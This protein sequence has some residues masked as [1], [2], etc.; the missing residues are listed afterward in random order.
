MA[1]MREVTPA[2]NAP[3]TPTVDARQLALALDHSANAI[4]LCDRNAVIQY[5][6]DGFFRMF[7][8]TREEA[9]GRQ[10][11]HL[12]LGTHT[13]AETIR[14]LGAHHLAGKPHR[15]DVLGYRRDGSPLWVS[16]VATPVPAAD[17]TVDCFINVLTDITAAKTHEVLQNKVLDALV[18]E[19]SLAET[20]SLIC[21]EIERVAPDLRASVSQ[22][23][24]NH[25][26][27]IIA[28]P[29]LPTAL[30]DYLNGQPVGVG[31]GICGVAA[32][33][34]RP[35]IVADIAT[36][37]LCAA[38]AGEL[39]SSG[40]RACWANPI[41]SSS[42]QVLGTLAFHYLEAREPAPWHRAL[43]ELSLHLC[44]LALER[45]HTRARVHQLA[46][47]DA[48]TGLP[49][50]M[51]FT[52]RAEQLLASCEQ[53]G[54]Q[55]A[56]LFIG[57]DRFK[58]INESQGHSAGD[59]LL[60]DVA[61]RMAGVVGPSALFG[62]QV[63]DEFLL[64]VPGCSAVQTAAICERLL[65]AIAAPLNVGQITVNASA[66]IGVAMY[67]VDG[68]DI[69]TLLR[70]ADL[71]MYR[72]KD[73]GGSGFR[74][75][76]LDMNR[77]AQERVVME[78]ALREALR[79]DQLTLHYQPQ[80]CSRTQQLSGVEALL[81]WEHPHMGSV[82]PARFIP[83]A[84]ECGLMDELSLWVL[85]QACDDLGH[86]RQRGVPVPRISVNLSASNF[87]NATLPDQLRGLLQEYHLGAGD[88]V[89]EM[90][91]SVMLSA[92]A[93]VLRNLDALHALGFCLSLDDFGTGYSSLSH[94]HRLPISELKLDRSFV[95]DI[96]HSETARSLIVSILRIG[97]NLN[98]LV[99]AEGVETEC[100]RQF[101][102]AH[103]CDLLQG[104]LFSPALPAP[105]L[106]SWL[107]HH[108]GTL[109][110][111]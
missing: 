12:L 56:A 101:L 76:S 16:V 99:V 111:A 78:A 70:H 58:R 52:A 69:D 38:H 61:Q 98:K 88:L 7:G 103:G 100:Q 83:M 65:G 108:R 90:T 66:S 54:Q 31:G 17:G 77:V 96:E 110:A 40:L 26:L 97:E 5:S 11:Q 1:A 36:D 109:P 13:D 30:V 15:A 9:C 41:R 104:F 19:V 95:Q 14:Q 3:S 50:R 49:N 27:R 37:P 94:L 67:P 46:F 53:N 25:M 82:S 60:R 80:L 106:E 2:S 29:S 45:E 34:N 32:W 92:H 79:G 51:M 75:F 85:R 10:P 20:M 68:R 8:Y 105:A 43:V 33:R 42:G 59:G 62:R 18:R 35:V 102:A 71:A 28:A 63:G 23:D 81:R 72:A 74:F 91:E 22:I 57:L 86:W 84:E 48:L 73:E 6:N 39:L 107:E 21:R 44:A 64:L 4:L 47:Y 93:R 55:V 87:D 89:L 24:A